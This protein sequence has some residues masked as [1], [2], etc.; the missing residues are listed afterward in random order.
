M[1][2]GLASATPR[3][4]VFRGTIGDIRIADACRLWAADTPAATAQ[5]RVRPR[6]VRTKASTPRRAGIRAAPFERVPLALMLPPIAGIHQRVVAPIA[7]AKLNHR[8]RG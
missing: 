6:I 3:T 8:R 5:I 4:K 7:A 1:H 2:P